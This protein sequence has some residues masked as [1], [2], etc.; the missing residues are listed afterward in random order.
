MI[1][2]DQTMTERYGWVF[3]YESPR[4]LETGDVDQ[5]LLGNAPVFVDSNGI[6]HHIGTVDALEDYLR[7][8]RIPYRD[9]LT[10]HE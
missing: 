4:Y 1:V 9:V 5:R 7:I 8:L 6:V 2:D 10:P 3:F